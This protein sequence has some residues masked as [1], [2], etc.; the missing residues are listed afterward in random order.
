MPGR[1]QTKVSAWY[2]LILGAIGSVSDLGYSVEGAYAIPVILATGIPLRYASLTLSLSPLLGLIVQP[3]FGSV[4]DQCQC[5]WG[6]RRPF[7]LL[8]GVAAVICSGSLPYY[9]Y[10][11]EV[12]YSNYLI[13]TCV[14]LCIM[15]FDLSL[16]LLLIPGKAIMFDIVPESQENIVNLISSAGV[17]FYACLGFALGGVKWSLVTGKDHSIQTQA[18]IVF[19]VTA[20]VFGVVTLITVLCIREDSSLKTKT[21]TAINYNI[22]YA[23]YG[24]VSELETTIHTTYE[25]KVSRKGC[26]VCLNPLKLL[27]ESCID[28]FQF[29]YCMSRHMW[30]L[31]L[32]FTMAYAADFAFVY[33]FTT[34]VGTVVYDGDANAPVDSDTYKDYMSGVRMGSFGLAIGSGVNIIASFVFE[35]FLKYIS[36][37]TLLLHVIAL[38]TCCLCL[39]MYFHQLPAT[40]VLCSVYGLYLGIC[41]SVPYGFISNYKVRALYM[42]RVI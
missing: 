5:S 15:L 34:F 32:T 24:S 9:F 26:I 37:K 40:L 3:F 41:A 28:I 29:G 38:F 20:V 33:S 31:A 23:K 6:K 4:T 27:K 17:G 8:V 22:K 30:I 11:S 12:P 7:I 10:M 1:K 19:G 14:V 21:S 42:V 36:I 2:I 13:P 16:S 25:D 35:K 39:L 18:E